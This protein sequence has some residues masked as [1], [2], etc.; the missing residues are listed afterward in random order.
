MIKP[1]V[2]FIC[3]DNSCRTQMAE[4]FLRDLAG[5]RFEAISAGAAAT[6]LDPDAVAVMNEVG[7]DIRGQTPKKVEQFLGERVAYLVTVC[8]REIERTCPIFPG[9][10]W[11][12]KWPVE[13]PTAAQNAY[14]RRALTRR[15]R[16]EIRQH[17]V[18]F[19]EEHA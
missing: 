15:V 17:V 2:L 4:A 10:T 13:S 9:A 12:L 6:A 1:R 5:D 7:L 3:S 18:K 19:V 11:R 8:E 14:E 16:D